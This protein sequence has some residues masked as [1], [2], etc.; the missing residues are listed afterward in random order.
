MDSSELAAIFGVAAAIVVLVLLLM[1]ADRATAARR[2]EL[3]KGVEF[4][5]PEWVNGGWDRVHFAN[6][7]IAE[8]NRRLALVMK[9]LEV[10]DDVTSK[11]EDLLKVKFQEAKE[12]MAK[13]DGLVESRKAAMVEDLKK[14]EEE[15]L[16]KKP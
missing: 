15:V 10:K 11:L 8:L 12:A 4:K 5:Y 9:H 1:R 14:I 7:R 3:T 16:G 13:I 6:L 2:Q